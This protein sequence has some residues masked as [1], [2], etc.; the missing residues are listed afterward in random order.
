MICPSITNKY[1]PPILIYTILHCYYK[2]GHVTTNNLK[3]IK[4]INRQLI[5][6]YREINNWQIKEVIHTIIKK[7]LY[8]TG[9]IAS[10]ALALIG[11]FVPLLPTT[12]LLLLSVYLFS[13]SSKRLH[14][15]T[16]NNRIFGR[17]LRNYRDGR[18]IP[19]KTKI[20]SITLLWLTI[21]ISIYTVGQ[22]Y[23]RIIL[24]IVAVVIT[25]HLSKKKT[26]RSE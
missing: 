16:L 18:G 2:T 10:L 3:F 4:L 13:K 7:Y 8:I 14:D 21:S 22:L 5:L 9:G 6:M 15:W 1:L 23:L 20:I 26:Y 24:L 25:V 17:Y 12:P 11:V 19:W